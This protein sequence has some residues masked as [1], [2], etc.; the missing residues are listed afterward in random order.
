MLDTEKVGDYLITNGQI[1][2]LEPNTE[3]TIGLPYITKMRTM[4]FAVPGAV[5]EGSIKRILNCLV[6]SVRTRGGQI[7]VESHG[8]L[9]MIDLDIPYSLQAEDVE[10]FGEGGF[11]KAGRVT[12]LFN[13]PYPA[14]IL[15]LV[16]EVEMIQ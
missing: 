5:T 10:K 6:R 14:T 2:G 16:F 8:Q 7:G 9:N 12:L 4:A 13:D 11:D 15:C 3:Y 1:I